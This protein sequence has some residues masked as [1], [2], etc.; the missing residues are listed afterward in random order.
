MY[1]DI[2]KRF[3]FVI[4]I[5]C[6]FPGAGWN[7]ISYLA[8]YFMENGVDC[9]VLSTFSPSNIRQKKICVSKN[10]QIYNVVPQISVENPFFLILNNIVAFIFSLPFFLLKKPDV[11]VIS[12]FPANQLIAVFW[13]SKILR[14][15]LIIDYRDEIEDH[16][17]LYGKRWKSFYLLIKKVFSR[18]YSNSY[19]IT[20]TTI[21]VADNLVQRGVHNIHIVADGADTTIFKPLDKGK[22]RNRLNIPKNIF[23]IVFLGYIYHA[24]RVDIVVKTLKLL[25]E[26]NQRNE[27]EYLLLIV[28]GGEIN[29]LLKYADNL[30]V[31]NMVRYVGLVKDALEVVKVINAADVGI[32][33]YDDNPLW[34]RMYPTKLF[35]YTA[36]G[37]PVIGTVYEDS[38]LAEYLRKHSIGITVPPLD[39]DSLA[40]AIE[41]I[42]NI[43]KNQSEFSSKALSFARRYDKAR[44]A[45]ELLSR[46]LKD[47]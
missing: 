37:L 3:L 17:I 8:R 14:T 16:W 4:G 46:I 40:E 38:I 20:P 24:Y 12:V 45:E 39:I 32:I 26:K 18:I 27:S 44:I 9:S 31:S 47:N 42:R 33:P 25:K 29:K 28:G 30:G 43:L 36:C 41:H 7:R 34:K 19:L 35:E 21:A 10:I 5:T 11:V 2:K 1:P 15:K 22:M 23:V 6:P 13:L